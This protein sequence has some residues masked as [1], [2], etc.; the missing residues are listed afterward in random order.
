MSAQC[1][2]VF[3]YVFYDV[4]R[5]KNMF[6]GKIGPSEHTVLFG[7]SDQEHLLYLMVDNFR[8]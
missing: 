6:P 1:R 8:L 2:K 4:L 7:Y 3:F 5:R